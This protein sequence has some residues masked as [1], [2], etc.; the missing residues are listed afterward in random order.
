MEGRVEGRME[1]RK[2]DERREAEKR[3]KVL[4]CKK[5]LFI[6]CRIVEIEDHYRWRKSGKRYCRM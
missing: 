4:E 3:K 2:R 6:F 1:E 5:I